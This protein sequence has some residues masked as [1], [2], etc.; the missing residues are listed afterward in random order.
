MYL[1]MYLVPVTGALFLGLVQILFL[2]EIFFVPRRGPP[3][4][5]EFCLSG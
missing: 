2:L 3:S 5:A 1:C 4:D